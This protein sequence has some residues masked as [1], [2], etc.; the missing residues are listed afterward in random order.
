MHLRV[1][2]LGFGIF[3]VSFCAS[4]RCADAQTRILPLG[5]SITHGGQLHASYRYPLWFDLVQAGYAVDFVGRETQ[6]DGGDPPNLAWYPDYFTTFDADHEGYWGFRTDQI[7][8]LIDAAALAGQPDVVLVHLGTND[9][10]QSGAA[11]VT[12]ADTHLRLIIDRLR[13]Q[14]PAVVVLLA[15]VIPIGMGTSYF[16]N[17][18]Q[19]PALNAVIDQIAADL[20]NPAAPVLVVDLNTG[21][22][23]GTMMQPDG[24][25]PN[26]VGEA[27]LA[28]GWRAV[29]ETLLPSGNPP[30]TIQV[31]APASGA[32]FVAP[33]SIVITADAFDDGSVEIVRFFADGVEIGSDNTAPYQFSWSMPPL[34]STTLT[35]Q[36][37]DDLGATT[38]SSPVSITVVPVG[39][40]VPIFVDNASFESPALLDGDLAA[41]PASFGGWTFAASAETFLGIFNPPAGSYPGAVGNGTATGGDGVNA[42]YLFNNDQG[43]SPESVEATQSLLEVVEAGQDYLLSVAIGKFLPGQPYAF[44]EY[45][46]YRI[47]LLAGGTL[48]AFDEDSIEPPFGEFLEAALAVPASAIDPALIGQPLSIRLTLSSTQAPRSTHFDNVVLTKASALGAQLI[49]GDCNGDG[50]FDISDPITGLGFLF[51]G[52]TPPTLPCDDAC[53]CNDDGVIDVADMICM[54]AGLFGN[55]TSPPVAPHPA[56]GTDPSADGLDCSSSS[57]P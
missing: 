57:C 26:V 56:C 2:L 28:D 43:G 44:S 48:L 23:L 25:H 27:F 40:P 55:P 12:T 34:G 15:R 50:E 21:F 24:L 17:A 41:G 45:G 6:I 31:T 13:L 22:D 52:G 16:A 4:R 51:P 5:D 36:A 30:P 14:N 37:Q 35:A 20:D 19:V 11:G 1:V 49:R 46:G 7:A 38:D 10:G 8:S 47:E 9:I 29:L 33:A 53:D 32:T 39:A 18:A 54:L 3:V 42:A